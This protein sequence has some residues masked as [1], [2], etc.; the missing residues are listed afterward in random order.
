MYTSADTTI[1]RLFDWCMARLPNGSHAAHDHAAHGRARLFGETFYAIIRLAVSSELATSIASIVATTVLHVI[2]YGWITGVGVTFAIFVHEVGHVWELWRRGYLGE[3][4]WGISKLYFIP[5]VGAV[6]RLGVRFRNAEDEAAVGFMGPLFGGVATALALAVWLSIPAV[7]AFEGAFDP[8]VRK[9]LLGVI[10]MSAF[11]NGLNVVLTVRPF[12][13]G[14][15]TQAVHPASRFFG[16]PVLALLSYILA[17]PWVILLW[18]FYFTD[19]RFP[20]EWRRVW[21]LGAFTIAMFVWVLFDVHTSFWSNLFQTA[22][23]A[24][25]TF[26]AAMYAKS[27]GDWDGEE[28]RGELLRDRVVSQRWF[29]RYAFLLIGH[30]ALFLAV[31]YAFGGMAM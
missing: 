5:F 16:L 20:N 14:R 22:I 11:F 28:R 26:G 29:V 18:M 24:L 27:A 6:L 31:A 10:L 1:A 23:A 12:D 19:F 25:T 9:E 7:A 2:A 4:F 8:A 3:R 17:E 13:G 15:V 21:V 30:A